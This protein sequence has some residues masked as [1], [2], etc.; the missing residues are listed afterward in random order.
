MRK[1]SREKIL[2]T[3]RSLFPRYGYNGISI[4]E[5]AAK[6]KLT[7]GAVYFHFKNKKDIYK[8]NGLEAIDILINKFR[9]GL[10]QKNTPN[11][12]LIST[13]DSYLSFFEENRDYYNILMEAK[14]DYSIEDQ[15]FQNIA[16]KFQELI[17]VSTEPIRMGIQDRTFR[18]VDPQMLSM[19]LAAV[20]EGM[21][22]Y[23][24]M[25]MLEIMNISDTDFRNFMAD[26]IGNGIQSDKKEI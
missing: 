8:A 18:E 1:N 12:K 4:R 24:K 13:F 6:A 17:E 26:I 2:E 3:A 15:D 7:T 10:T 22:Q 14:A 9:D 21:M 20:T 23:K 11:Q 19:L 16:A 5:I 25:G